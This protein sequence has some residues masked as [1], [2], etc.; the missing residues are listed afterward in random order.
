MKSVRTRLVASF[1]GTILAVFLILAFVGIYYLIMAIETHSSQSMQLLSEENTAELDTYF[2][3]VERAV[4][5]MEEHLLTEVDIVQ[6]Q[7]DSK[8]RD[9]IYKEIE[10]IA[11]NS[12]KI[13]EHVEAVYFRPD[14]I[15]YGGTA[16]FFL[17]AGE[18]GD[19]N[20]LTPTDILQ[21]KEDDT[22]HVGWYYEPVKRGAPLW[23]EPYS[24]ENINIY[25]ISYVVPVYLGRDLLGVLGM[26]I[27][28]TL[29]HQ[30]IDN[31]DYL[32]STGALISEGGNLLYH[33]DHTG[34]LMKED[35]TGEIA[36]ASKFYDQKYIDTGENYR[37]SVG[38][39]KY[40]IMISRLKNGML[41]SISTPESELFRF[42]TKMLIQ[43]I[44]I[45]TAALA[46]VIFVSLRMTRKIIEPIRELTDVSSRIAKGELEQ[47]IV[48]TEQDEIGSLADSIRKISV[49]LKRYI[50]FIHGQ[51]YLDTMTGLKNKAAYL[52]EE[53]RL[54]R[55]IKEKMASFMIYIFDINGLKRMNDTKGHEYGDMLIKDAALI[56]K[57]VFGADRVYRIGG[58]EFIALCKQKTGEEIEREF[59]YFDE[60]VRV[61][62]AK[63]NKYE[64]DL[65]ISKGYAVYDPDTDP[66]YASVFSRADEDMYQCKADYYTTHG[67]RRR[68]T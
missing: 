46:L 53:S 4:K 37:Y 64:E 18:N 38:G 29:V 40:R 60:E 39:S 3:G 32:N 35:F 61:L 25:M 59:A 15:L 68:R 2:S 43:L 45:F 5:V 8:Y 34:G 24:N 63:N 33:R 58:D 23:M 50:D 48:Y 13:I 62:N 49:E 30:V 19:Y 9:R 12:S 57:T 26:D 56:I 52:E 10:G 41:L 7:S 55:L 14:P 17:T 54:E 16:G 11:L 66:D 31:I 6:Y 36:A 20:S 21:Y 22:E 42:R 44:L 65:S 1:A 47:E 28:M 51:A 27:D 67:D